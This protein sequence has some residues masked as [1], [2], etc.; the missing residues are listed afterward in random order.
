MYISWNKLSFKC[1]VQLKEDEDYE[2]EELWKL[3]PRELSFWVASNFRENPQQQQMLLQV[4]T[5]LK[6]MEN[7]DDRHILPSQL[8]MYHG[9]LMA[10]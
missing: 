10:F 1:T 9:V 7:C 5:I 8:Y 3:G 4:L 6:L 2:P